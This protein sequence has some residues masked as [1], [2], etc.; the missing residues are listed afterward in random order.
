M[1]NI[2]TNRDGKSTVANLVDERSRKKNA[3]NNYEIVSFV[4]Q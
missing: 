3:L 1:Q 4:L 2:G